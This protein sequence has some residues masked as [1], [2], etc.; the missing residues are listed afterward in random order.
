MEKFHTSKK[1]LGDEAYQKLNRSLALACAL[2]LRPISMVM[3]RGFRSFCK[4]L[5]PDYQVP[6]RKTVTTKLM[7]IYDEEKVDIIKLLHSEHYH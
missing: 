1:I 2:D 4:L 3:D 6:C 5:N 7:K